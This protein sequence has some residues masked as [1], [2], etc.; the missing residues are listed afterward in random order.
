MTQRPRILTFVA[1]T[2]VSTALSVALGA[3][4]PRL[5]L[6]VFIEG[7]R[8]E[9]LQDLA[10]YFGQ[11]G[12]NRL[13]RQGAVITD[14]D[15][16]PGLDAASATALLLT[17]AAPA[18]NGIPATTIY[19][20]AKFRSRNVFDDGKTMGNYTD[21]TLSPSALQVS[22]IADE[23]KIAGNGV[24]M[25]YAIAGDAACAIVQGGHCANSAVF[26]NEFTGNWATSTFYK[27]FPVSASMSNRT[28]PLT[29]RLDTMSWT[30]TAKSG[31]AAWMLPEHLSAYPFRY[32]FKRGDIDRIPHYIAS[33]MANADIIRLATQYLSTYKL[34]TRASTD[35]LTLTC[36][37]EAYPGTRTTEARYETIDAYMRADA[38]LAS[39]F[40]AVDRNTAGN[41][42]A[43]IIVA[44][45]PPRQWRRPDDD[46]W[47]LPDGTF[48]TRK[49]MSLLNMYLMAIHGTGQ[50]V[51]GYHNG[52]VYLNAELIKQNNKDTAA[53]RAEAANFLQRMSG[54]LQAYTIDQIINGTAPVDD[55]QGL[56]RNTT[57]AYAGDIFIQVIPGWKLLDDYNRAGDIMPQSAA[58]SAL[59]TAPVFM[60]A[61]EVP[62]QT[63]GTPVDARRIAPT[64]TRQLRIRSP[65]GA[66]RPPLSLQK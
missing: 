4:Q 60:L 23:V 57:I 30:P 43:V 42:G 56:R 15:F 34:G 39:L 29:A 50:W 32:T 38:A 5:V 37:L 26:I 24:G 8:M 3:K 41:G 64:V 52:Q 11:D 17:G 44:G 18:A 66:N 12:F 10:P 25:V 47:G 58:V 6:G 20:V 1:A 59:T 27:E 46:T 51:S 40:K 62:A 9:N 63:I 31:E 65:N 22:T 28:A 13:L 14:A 7:L 21:M 53:M 33:P 19:D 49:A 61:P 54:V 45:L 16:G 35:M 55:P 48:S 36:N 2:M